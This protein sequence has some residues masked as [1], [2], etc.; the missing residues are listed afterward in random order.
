MTHTWSSPSHAPGTYMGSDYNRLSPE[1][2]FTRK[3]VGGNNEA[4]IWLNL[5][6]VVAGVTVE[7]YKANEPAIKAGIADFGKKVDSATDAVKQT[8]NDTAAAT[9]RAATTIK[10][11]WQAVSN[12][13]AVKTTA[14]V[15]KSVAD[16]ISKAST[17]VSKALTQDTIVK[18][19]AVEYWEKL[20]GK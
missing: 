17:E 8:Y 11:N 14:E 3:I 1:A 19:K 20:F 18:Q 16:E 5:G 12:S 4:E 6:V 15:A 2:T 10:E 13:K 7:A 9:D